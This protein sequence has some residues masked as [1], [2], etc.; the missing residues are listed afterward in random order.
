M[1]RAPFEPLGAQARWRTVYEILQQAAVDDVVTYE[2]LGEAL[3]LHPYNDRAI[4]QQAMARAAR[5]HEETDKRAIDSVRSVGYRIVEPREH[6]TLAVRQ[7]KKSRRALERGHSKVVN[8]DFNNMDPNIRSA[9]EILASGFAQQA[10]FN[11]RIELRQSRL[12][13]ALRDIAD[14]Q[15]QDRKRTEEEVTELRERLARLESSEE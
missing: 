2:T 12:D 4:I 15:H 7:Q 8:V 5:E 11:R 10:G 14:S 6:M 9:F 1:G 13:R 3:D